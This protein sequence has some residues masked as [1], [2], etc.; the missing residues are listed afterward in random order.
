MLKQLFQYQI[1]TLLQ[2]QSDLLLV[3]AGAVFFF[4]II[5]L[6]TDLRNEK[7]A[8]QKALLVISSKVVVSALHAGFAGNRF[9]SYIRTKNN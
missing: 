1:A 9:K 3:M 5:I 8:R 6:N 7:S 4:F 2:I